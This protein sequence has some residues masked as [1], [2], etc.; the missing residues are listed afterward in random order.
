MFS[1]W[2][3]SISLRRIGN[4]LAESQIQ[5]R[6]VVASCVLKCLGVLKVC[7][8]RQ[9]PAR[10]Y[11]ANDLTRELELLLNKWF[12]GRQPSNQSGLNRAWKIPACA[13]SSQPMLRPSI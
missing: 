13:L 11:S 9:F 3:S 8:E 10:Q 12:G 7:S 6:V 1:C 2:I 4:L 5:G